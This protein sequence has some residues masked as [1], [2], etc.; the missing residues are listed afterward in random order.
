MPSTVIETNAYKLQVGTLLNQIQQ[1]SIVTF[2]A[3]YPFEGDEIPVGNFTIFSLLWDP[4]KNIRV[5]YI[6]VPERNTVFL[7]SIT[8][9]PTQLESRSADRKETLLKKL[10][11][12]ISTRII[13]DTLIG[14]V[15]HIGEWF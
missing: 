15:K 12:G 5:G 7:L 2:L 8:K 6:L 14:I 3:H 4:E 13:A 10:G 11:I 1:Q 9:G